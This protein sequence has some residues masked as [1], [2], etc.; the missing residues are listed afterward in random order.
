M[1]LRWVKERIEQKEKK[2]KKHDRM[3]RREKEMEMIE[4]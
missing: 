1:N 3:V 4:E 2:W